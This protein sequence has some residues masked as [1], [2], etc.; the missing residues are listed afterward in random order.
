MQMKQP[1]TPQMPVPEVAKLTQQDLEDREDFQYLLSI[2]EK[3]RAVGITQPLDYVDDG[4]DLTIDGGIVDVSEDDDPVEGSSDAPVTIV[5]FS[6]YECP[7]CA[8]FH[9]ETFGQIKSK[10]I[11]L[12]NSWQ[13]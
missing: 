4:S 9:S 8:R 6:D 5:E 3:Q 13:R 12:S 10:Y 11:V 2:M 7:F 1:D